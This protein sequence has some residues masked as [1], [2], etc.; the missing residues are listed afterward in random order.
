MSQNFILIPLQI[1]IFYPDMRLKLSY[2]V[3][4]S[5][6]DLGLFYPILEIYYPFIRETVLE[7]N[8][9]Q[10]QGQTYNHILDNTC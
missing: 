2:I 1:L 10:S 4:L 8:A 7:P 6:P 3:T 9:G 5:N